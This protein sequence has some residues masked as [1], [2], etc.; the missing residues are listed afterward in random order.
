MLCMP[1]YRNTTKILIV[2]TGRGLLL[3]TNLQNPDK[4]LKE[5]N[6]KNNLL[7]IKDIHSI[8]DGFGFS[9][10]VLIIFETVHSKKH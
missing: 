9:V 7:R 3:D 5:I 4:F 10:E 8:R 2:G 6:G 1:V